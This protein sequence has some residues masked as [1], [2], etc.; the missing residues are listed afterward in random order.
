MKKTGWLVFL[1]LGLFSIEMGI[2]IIM[3]SPLWELF[4]VLFVIVGL[5]MIFLAI[6]M[7]PQINELV[8]YRKELIV[9]FLLFIF[10]SLPRA[11]FQR[12]SI[13]N[14]ELDMVA[15]PP[16]RILLNMILPIVIMVLTI[17]IFIAKDKS[18]AP[19][20]HYNNSE[21]YKE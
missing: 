14:L 9:I 5:V 11:I 3:A 15:W 13:S 12:I 18:Q 10:L 21:E 4:T 7:A 2:I 6:A 17:L 8:A 19:T 16:E 20:Y 1:I